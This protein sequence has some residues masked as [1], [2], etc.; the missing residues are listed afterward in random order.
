VLHRVEHA[1]DDPLD[2]GDDAPLLRLGDDGAWFVF[3]DADVFVR[4]VVG[5]VP[6]HAALPSPLPVPR[7]PPS[8]PGLTRQSITLAKKMDARIKS[9]HDDLC[10][11]CIVPSYDLSENSPRALANAALS[12]FLRGR[13]LALCSSPSEQRGEMARRQA[14]PG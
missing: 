13:G 5:V 8:L 10:S 14:Q 7:T 4:P 2:A 1:P 12:R 3:D 11:C 6:V 9:G